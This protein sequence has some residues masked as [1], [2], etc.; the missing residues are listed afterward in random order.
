[1][2]MYDH[3]G[4]PTKFTPETKDKILVA[5]RKGAPYEIAANYA[6]ISYTTFRKWILL[7][8]NEQIPEYV[9]FLRDLKEAEGH[10]ALI[11]MDKIDKAMNDG[12]WQAA[13]WKLERRHYKHFSTNAQ[14]IE[15]EERLAK[16]ED[17]IKSN[18][19]QRD[20][21]QATEEERRTSETE[22][23]KI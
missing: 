1:M 9:Q 20:G 16:I 7:A 12:A 13:A 17:N 8:E 21:V 22:E 18:K 19:G 14:N 6:G 10:T 15:H 4:Q 5:I 11:W 3:P 2:P 23:T